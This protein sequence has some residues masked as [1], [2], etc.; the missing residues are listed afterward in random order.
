MSLSVYYAKAHDTWTW[1]TPEYIEYWVS[2]KGYVLSFCIGFCS[3][4]SHRLPIIRN[5]LLSLVQTECVEKSNKL[6]LTCFISWQLML[7]FKHAGTVTLM[8]QH[9]ASPDNRK[10]PSV[11][12][13]RCAKKSLEYFDLQAW[14]SQGIHHVFPATNKATLWHVSQKYHRRAVNHAAGNKKN[15]ARFGDVFGFSKSQCLFIAHS[16]TN[17]GFEYVKRFCPL[18]KQQEKMIEIIAAMHCWPP[19]PLSRILQ[20]PRSCQQSPLSKH[21]GRRHLIQNFF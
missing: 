16:K 8:Y 9:L 5:N 20:S 21:W 11:W 12:R 6:T 14:E 7:C 3:V 17:W 13:H 1:P 19:F 2:I 18:Y 15:V 4:R 10:W